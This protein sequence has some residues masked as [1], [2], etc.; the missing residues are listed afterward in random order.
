[1][2]EK[3]IG[4]Y[5]PEQSDCVSHYILLAPFRSL[6]ALLQLVKDLLRS[7]C[8]LFFDSETRD[9]SRQMKS[10]SPGRISQISKPSMSPA[11]ARSA[12]GVPVSRGN[13]P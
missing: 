9:G 5:F 12:A 1:M 7:E 2:S 3:H 4:H 8:R 13:V 10:V 11:A 6:P